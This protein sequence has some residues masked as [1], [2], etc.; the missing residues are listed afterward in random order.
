MPSRQRKPRI[1]IC[2]DFD[3]TLSPGNMQEYNFFPKLGI[4][5]KTFWTEVK[6]FAKEQEADEILAY[7]HLML[8]KARQSR[9]VEITAKAFKDYG[10]TVDLFEGVTN[11]F[12]RIN[13]YVDSKAIVEHFIVSSGIKEMIL[14]SKIKGEFKKVFASSFFYDQHDVAI[15]PAVALNYTAKTQMLFRI[16]KN[17][18]DVSDNYSLNKFLE[19]DKRPIPF[20]HMIYIGDGL[21]DV[22]CMK[23]VKQQ[24]GHSIAVD[25]PNRTKKGAAVDLL[26]QKRCDFVAQANYRK[27]NKLEKIVNSII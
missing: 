18:L 24:G 12:N 2:Y 4:K 10:K 3:G 27:G 23:L 17:V 6:N 9:E 15:A 20:N 14:G 19:N 21:T 11:W 5:P 8:E 13:K 22:P 7:M 1:A 25:K 26:E 16:N